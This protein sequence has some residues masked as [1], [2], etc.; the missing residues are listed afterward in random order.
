MLINA[1]QLLTERAKVSPDLTAVV[2][3]DNQESL[4]YTELNACTNRLAHALV[5]L[6]IR[7]GDRVGILMSNGVWYMRT[8][9]AMAKIGAISVFLNWRL[10]PEELAFQI[11][12]SGLRALM[13]SPDQIVLVKPLMTRFPH[14]ELFQTEGEAIGSAR[15]LS[16][17]ASAMPETEPMLGASGDEAQFLMYTS[18]TTGKPKGAVHTHNS[19]IAWSQC[20]TATTEMRLGDRGLVLAPFFHIAGLSLLIGYVHRGVT[21]VIAKN[22]DAGNVWSLFEKERINHS[23]AVPVML[24][25]LYEHPKRLTSDHK[26]LRWLMVGAAP[27]PTS[28]IEDFA[29]SGIDLYQVYGS[30][31]T[32]GGICIID[33]GHARS[34]AGSTGRPYFGL[35][36][37]V[38]DHQGCDVAPGVPGEVITRG[39][40]L[41]KGYWNR[42]EDTANA[43][44]DGWFALDDIAVVDADGFIYIKDRSKDVIISGG[45][46]IYPAEVEDAL[47]RHPAVRDVA[48]IAQPCRRW[49]ETPAAIIV[50][51]ATRH[52][53]SIEEL[54][55]ELLELCVTRLARYKHPRVLEFVESL[56]RSSTGKV[57]KRL[58]RDRF[59]GPAKE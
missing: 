52:T 51:D 46:N 40:H 26:L 12:D 35:D 57:L 4:T 11:E 21:S 8:Y 5:T 42:P 58:L 39:P 38:V 30:T 7:P 29:V 9:Y 19:T 18:G 33:P 28:T 20:A 47:M 43:F 25:L 17:V 24:N 50:A 54:R 16:A 56:P 48:V 55:R 13:F 34:K 10:T 45:E 2:D 36:V 59:P 31:E 41:I 23:F 1:G 3:S 22:F 32:H 15:I 6:G 53:L 14:I 49:G 27:L 37:R 44:K